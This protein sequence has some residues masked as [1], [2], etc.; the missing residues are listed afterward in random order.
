MI[1]N[2]GVHTN[3]GYFNDFDDAVAC[4]EIAERERFGEFRAK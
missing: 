3:L 1:C 4:R 2:N